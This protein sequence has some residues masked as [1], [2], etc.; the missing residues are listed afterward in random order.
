MSRHVKK[1][2]AKGTEKNETN[3]GRPLIQSL[4]YTVCHRKY[5]E[6]LNKLRVKDEIFSK[7]RADEITSTAMGDPL[8]ALYG[9]NML[10]KK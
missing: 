7:I 3:T 6:I 1:C 4:V 10:K 2:F 8:I 5:G 9:D